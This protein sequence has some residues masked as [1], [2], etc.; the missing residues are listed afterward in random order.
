MAQFFRPSLAVNLARVSSQGPKP[1]ATG[2]HGS[3]HHFLDVQ[4]GPHA[5][6]HGNG[7][8]PVKEPVSTVRLSNP[9]AVGGAPGPMTQTAQAHLGHGTEFLEKMPRDRQCRW[10]KLTVGLAMMLAP[11]SY[12][13]TTTSDP[14]AMTQMPSTRTDLFVMFGSDFNRPGILPRANYSIG[15]GH[16][17]GFLKRNPLG[18]ELIVDYSYENSGSHGFLHTNF[19][20]HTE[21]VGIMRTFAISKTRTVAGYTWIQSGITSYSGNV[22]VLNRLASSASIGLMIRVNRHYSVWIQESF[23]KVVTA[24]WYTT[25]SLAYVYSR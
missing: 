14:M 2:Y 8:P 1:D 25:T 21:S 15:V 5:V 17:F 6:G 24:P 7:G 4:T 22:H 9:G 12:S 11:L 3:Y 10:F 13:Q 18:D 16:V 23:N 19:G 20:E